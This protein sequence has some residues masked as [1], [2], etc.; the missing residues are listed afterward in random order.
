VAAALAE[1]EDDGARAALAE[2]QRGL[3][4]HRRALSEL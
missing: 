2:V 3:L 1:Q 4:A